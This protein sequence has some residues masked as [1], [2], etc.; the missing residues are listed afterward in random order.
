MPRV[1]G[2]SQVHISE[3][4]AIVENHVPLLEIA[5]PDPKQEDDIIGPAIAEMIPDLSI[6]H[7]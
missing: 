1:F 4:D 5:A 7:I 2:D 3:V 6:R